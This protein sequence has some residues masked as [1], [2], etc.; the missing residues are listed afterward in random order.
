MGESVKC[1]GCGEAGHYKKDCPVVGIAT[2]ECRTCGS[3]GHLSKACK[4][5][6]KSNDKGGGSQ[7]GAKGGSPSRQGGNKTGSGHSRDVSRQSKAQQAMRLLEVA[8]KEK[9]KIQARA[10]RRA[11]EYAA[12]ARAAHDL[13][14]SSDDTRSN[15]SKHSAKHTRFNDDNDEDEDEDDS[16]E[17]FEAPPRGGQAPRKGKGNVAAMGGFSR[18]LLFMSLCMAC[19]LPTQAL[20]LSGSSFIPVSVSDS[21]FYSDPYQ[22]ASPISQAASLG[23]LDFSQLSRARVFYD[24]PGPIEFVPPGPVSNISRLHSTAPFRLPLSS[25]NFSLCSVDFFSNARS[26][27]FD[28]PFRLYRSEEFPAKSAQLCPEVISVQGETSTCGVETPSRTFSIWFT[29]L[30]YSVQ[31]FVLGLLLFS[32]WWRLI[33]FLVG[34]VSRYIFSTRE[35]CDDGVIVH[36]DEIDRSGFVTR[37]SHCVL[38][39]YYTSAYKYR[40]QCEDFGVAFVGRRSAGVDFKHHSVLILDGGATLH[41][42]AHLTL[43]SNFRRDVPV[44]RLAGIGGIQLFSEG[45]GDLVL[46][47]NSRGRRVRFT[48]SDVYYIPNDVVSLI[49]YTYLC[50]QCSNVQVSQVNNSLHFCSVVGWRS[51]FE[52]GP[53]GGPACFTYVVISKFAT[54]YL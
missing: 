40:F 52:F 39:S 13:I 43:L 24:D 17:Q 16:V 23:S 28:N 18:L 5:P 25:S 54:W 42:V 48:I 32:H 47:L 7:S 49:S 4:R 34:S 31:G 38:Q 53:L 29:W 36:T 33:C 37:T 9:D 21:V 50:H 27:D 6:P 51:A 26:C 45:R 46:D 1:Y 41:C 35:P 14:S 11:N 8:K 2:K 3:V 30:V 44:I 10:D 20:P 22:L 19:T 12:A 15:N